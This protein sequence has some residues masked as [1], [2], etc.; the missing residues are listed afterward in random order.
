MIA[1]LPHTATCQCTAAGVCG[2]LIPEHTTI[3]ASCE[4]GM[5]QGLHYGADPA[6]LEARLAYLQAVALEVEHTGAVGAWGALKAGL[7]GDWPESLR[8]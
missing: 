8:A 7:L 2:R 1:T 4:V 5:C 3:C 6:L